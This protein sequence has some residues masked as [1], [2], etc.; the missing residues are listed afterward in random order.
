M[1][2]M[3]FWGEKNENLEDYLEKK[4]PEVSGYV[5]SEIA[6]HMTALMAINYYDALYAKEENRKCTRN[7]Y[8]GD[9]NI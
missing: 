7:P 3:K 2:H 5:R 4:I 9:K 1:E 8:S 6:T